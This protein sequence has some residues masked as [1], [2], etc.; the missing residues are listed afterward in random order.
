M[1][2][3]SVLVNT[4]RDWRGAFRAMKTLLAD[5]DDT[6]QVFKIMRR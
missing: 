1:A 2:A 3:N 4:K 6:V 5:P